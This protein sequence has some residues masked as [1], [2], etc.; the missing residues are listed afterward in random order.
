ML[1]VMRALAILALLL[2]TAVA[3]CGGDDEDAA[4]AS[5][6]GLQRP[7]PESGELPVDEF[8]AY[9]E[10]VDEEW[11]RDPVGLAQ[12][13]LRMAPAEPTSPEEPSVAFI[14]QGPLVTVVRE[15]IPDDS[16]RAERYVLE[17]DEDDGHWTLVSARWAQR[18]HDGRGHQDFSPEL[19]V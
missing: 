5:W 17:L 1:R 2:A 7:Y 15:G 13:F 6:G 10:A 9:A 12:A 11:E 18:C 16:V 4:P 14:N 3:A 8:R 19:C